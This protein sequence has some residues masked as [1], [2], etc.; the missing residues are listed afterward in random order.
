MLIRICLTFLFACSCLGAQEHPVVPHV[1]A[2]QKNSCGGRHRPG[3]TLTC[4]V[5]FDGDPD[6]GKVEVVFNLPD[7]PPPNHRGS[8]INFVL[9]NSRKIAPG[10]YAVSDV[11]PDCVPG[12]YILAAVSAGIAGKGYRLYSNGYGFHSELTVDFENDPEELE[13]L[14]NNKPEGEVGTSTSLPL[15]VSFPP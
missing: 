8:Y 2:L 4:F 12:Q 14:V 13:N 9:R 11:L 7:N 1:R 10:T 6:F 15:P 3:D 5:A